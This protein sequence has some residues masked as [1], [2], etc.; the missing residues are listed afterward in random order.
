[1][2]QVSTGGR[3]TGTVV[4][5]GTDLD[6][7]AFRY[8]RRG[9]RE[10]GAFSGRLDT[11]IEGLARLESVEET[12]QVKRTNELATPLIRWPGW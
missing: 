12:P 5:S 6:K 8:G 7:P 3:L 9:V 4:V 1:M 2:L 11:E 10:I